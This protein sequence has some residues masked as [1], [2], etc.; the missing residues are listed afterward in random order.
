MAA[1]IQQ[2]QADKPMAAHRLLKPNIKDSRLSGF[3]NMF[4]KE[5]GDWFHTRRWLTQLLVWF[6]II[7]LF[8]AFVLFAVPQIDRAQGNSAPGADE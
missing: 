1:N 2:P 6:A 3:G 5:T 7:N 8:M 4:A